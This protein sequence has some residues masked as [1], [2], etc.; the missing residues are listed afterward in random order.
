MPKQFLAITSILFLVSTVYVGTTNHT[1]YAVSPLI[2]PPLKQYKSGVPAEQIQCKD[3]L[4]HIIKY[5]NTSACVKSSTVTKLIER[6]WGI[7]P[8]QTTVVGNS[9]SKTSTYETIPNVISANNRFALN[10]YSQTSQDNLENNIFFSPLSISAAFA[11]ASEGAKGDTATQIQQ[12]F[13]LEKDNEKRRTSFS[14]MINN[15]NIEDTEYKLKIANALWLAEGFEPLAEYT[16]IAKTYYDSDVDNVDF[17]TNHGINIINQWINE[18]TEGKIPTIFP[19]DSTDESTR[20]AITNAIYFKGMWAEQFDEDNTHD[21]DFKLNSDKIVQVPTMHISKVF[22]YMQNEQLQILEM[23]YEG[24]KISMLILLPNDVDGIKSL[25]SSLDAKTLEE[26]TSNLKPNKVI[27]NMPKF[28]LENISYN[29]IPKLQELGIS[30]A[31]D[32][33][34]ADFS[35]ITDLEQLYIQMA[36]HKAYVEVNEE[37]TEAAAAT[38]ITIGTTSVPLPPPEFTADHPLFS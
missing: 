19:P 5:D 10:F 4:H 31:F 20:L 29:L 8:N 23:L 24:D 21:S 37:G 28:K 18:K 6:G 12:I 38:G 17:V 14:N 33:N 32:P 7:M 15:L 13:G 34:T 30:S 35:G 9:P 1:A 26:W 2:V 3:G 22:N 25:E 16:N 36:V 27:V 11:I